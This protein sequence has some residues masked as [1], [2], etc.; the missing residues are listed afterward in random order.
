MKE[1]RSKRLLWKGTR[2]ERYSFMLFWLLTPKTTVS[3]VEE[4]SISISYF[5][6]IKT[7]MMKTEHV[8]REAS[9][10]TVR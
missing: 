4:I 6:K 5:F 7:T 9:G 3:F 1:K 2:R 10:E 8:N